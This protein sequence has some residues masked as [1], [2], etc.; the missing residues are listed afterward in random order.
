GDAEQKAWRVVLPR[1][2][3]LRKQASE[4]KTDIFQTTPFD[5]SD[6]K[7]STPRSYDK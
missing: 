1:H 6:Q 3:G 4:R 7:T 2:R 5:D